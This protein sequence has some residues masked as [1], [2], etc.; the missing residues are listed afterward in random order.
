MLGGGKNP[1]NTRILDP[2]DKFRYDYYIR[3]IRRIYFKFK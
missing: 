1:D 2:E 3:Y